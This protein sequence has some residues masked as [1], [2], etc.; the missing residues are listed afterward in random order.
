MVGVRGGRARIG[1]VWRR[2][3][4]GG[5]R[6]QIGGVRQLGGVGARA[7]RIGLRARPSIAAASASEFGL[8]LP[9]AAPTGEDPLSAD[10]YDTIEAFQLDDSAVNA[11]RRL[12][13]VSINEKDKVLAKLRRKRD[14]KKPSPFVTTAAKNALAAWQEKHGDA[15]A[16]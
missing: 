11:L 9:P 5:G 13:A 4:H 1:G 10:D 15:G 12:A 6:I 16:R 7:W 2:R 14:I 3:G 8:P